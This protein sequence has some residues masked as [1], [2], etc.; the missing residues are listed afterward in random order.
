M[1][2][3]IMRGDVRLLKFAPPNKTRPVVVLTHDHS[4]PYLNSV[5]VATITSTMRGVP[6]EVIL[7]EDDGMKGPCVVNLHNVFTVPQ[8]DVG[9]RLGQ[10][11]PERMKEICTALAYAVDCGD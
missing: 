8:H 6:T 3:G 10:L 5:T 9:K 11:R 7:D 2:G 4:I 1:A